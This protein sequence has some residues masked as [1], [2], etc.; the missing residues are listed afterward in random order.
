MDEGAGLHH[1]IRH[2]WLT[3]SRALEVEA[4]ELRT[5]GR[6]SSSDRRGDRSLAALR[7]DVAMSFGRHLLFEVEA[8]RAE[9]FSTPEEAT[10]L[11]TECANI[12]LAGSLSHLDLAKE[13]R[14]HPEWRPELS[15]ILRD[16]YRD[17][18]SAL[19]ADVTTREPVPP[20]RRR[21]TAEE[22]AAALNEVERRS[23]E[24]PETIH[25][26]AGECMDLVDE[27]PAHGMNRV[28]VI[29]PW[30]ERFGCET[31]VTFLV[32]RDFDWIELEGFLTSATF[33][34]FI[35]IG[36]HGE[37]EAHNWPPRSP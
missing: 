15:E 35:R 4:A 1:R 28:L 30:S 20:F 9:D 10:S 8:F 14:R 36:A 11:I 24:Y 21:L 3:R 29:P 16:A 17:T 33:G 7:A 25:G 23:R 34:W 18:I 13:M 32:A 27:L 22:H 5:S 31:D 6:S 2:R 26:Y 37:W 12:A 19:E